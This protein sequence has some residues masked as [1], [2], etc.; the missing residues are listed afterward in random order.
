MTK[1]FIEGGP[2]FMG[3]LTLVLLVILALAV[4]NAVYLASGKGHDPVIVKS[5]LG[6]IKSAGLFGLITG[7]LG[8][9]IGLYQAF[10]AIQRIGEVSPALLA[11]G[12]K[13]SMITTM[14]GFVIFIIA[15]LLWFALEA[16]ASR[17]NPA[18]A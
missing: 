14:Y 4:V 8:Q 16:Y 9:L 6:Y 5:R 10:E 7:I 3:I 11:G 2:A 13:V 12:M 15:Y 1:L 17:N 18:E